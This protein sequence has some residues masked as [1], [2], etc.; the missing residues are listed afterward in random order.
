MTG[1]EWK[2]YSDKTNEYW[3]QN[4]DFVLTSDSFFG[5]ELL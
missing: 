1:K 2:L 3:N 5:Y 4:L